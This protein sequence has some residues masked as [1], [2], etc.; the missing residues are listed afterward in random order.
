[1][2][3]TQDTR[4]HSETIERQHKTAKTAETKSKLLKRHCLGNRTKDRA[5]RSGVAMTRE[6]LLQRQQGQLPQTQPS[7]EPLTWEAAAS[8]GAK[9]AR[10]ALPG[11]VAHRETAQWE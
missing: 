4:R 3:E 8:T 9:D 1:M 7:S 10:M 11:Q 2:D 6:I 5:E